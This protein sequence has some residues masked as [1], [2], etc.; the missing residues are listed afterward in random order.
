MKM[1]NKRDEQIQKKKKHLEGLRKAKRRKRN[2]E[3]I[4]ERP[5]PQ[6]EKKQK[7]LI[8]CEG[9]NTEPSYFKK[10]KLAT[11]TIKAVGE[12]YNTITLVDR[13]VQLST[14]EE[15]NQVWCVFDKDDF[16]NQNFNSA[17]FLDF[18]RTGKPSASRIRQRVRPYCP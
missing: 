2:Q 5:E 18:G 1:K 12:G 14:E 6:K 4:L 9:G 13:A 7:L 10:F 8:V 3:P 11:A 17:I 16:P 15:Y